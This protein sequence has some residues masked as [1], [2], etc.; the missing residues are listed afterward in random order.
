MPDK[1]RMQN[2]LGAVST[3]I[4]GIAS[5]YKVSYEQAVGHLLEHNGPRHAIVIPSSVL[6]EE[7]LGILE[8][9]VKYLKENLCLRYADIARIIARDQRAVWVTYSRASGKCPERLSLKGESALI[10]ASVFRKR[11]PLESLVFFLKGSRGL[12]LNEIA[13]L[14]G[15][16]NRSVWAVYNRKNKTEK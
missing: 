5:R 11:R 10:P 4:E 14:I 12:T 9:V 15:R 2:E 3:L 13:K 7:K 8:A 6:K 1:E 16:D